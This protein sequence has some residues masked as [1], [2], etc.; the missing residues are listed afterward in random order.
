MFE[1]AERRRKTAVQVAGGSNFRTFGTHNPYSDK[2]L[3]KPYVFSPTCALFA[4]C[5]TKL[6]FKTQIILTQ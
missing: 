6:T 5:E 3:E 2:G 4:H 1:D